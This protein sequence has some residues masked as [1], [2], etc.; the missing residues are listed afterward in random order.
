[1][2]WN[3][4]IILGIYVKCKNLFLKIDLF[5]RDLGFNKFEGSIPSLTKAVNLK[6]L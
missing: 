5:V 1:M 3:L 2:S 6:V 4:L